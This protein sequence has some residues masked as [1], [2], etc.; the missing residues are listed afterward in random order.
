MNEILKINGLEKNYKDNK[1]VDGISFDVY[2]GESLCILGP[3]GAGKSTTINMITGA[4]G[5]DGG[6]IC[7]SFSNGPL[8]T[9]FC[10]TSILVRDSIIRQG[11]FMKNNKNTGKS[12][13]Y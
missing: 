12:H 11:C 7:S 8:S 1:A 4:L 3:N 2:K 9:L 5:C 10:Y 6:T 13:S